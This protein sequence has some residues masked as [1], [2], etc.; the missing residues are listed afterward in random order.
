[1]ALGGF[2]YDVEDKNPGIRRM[3]RLHVRRT[4]REAK[5][6]FYW[7]MRILRPTQRFA[8]YTV[9]TFC[10]EVDDIVDEVGFVKDQRQAL[11]RWRQELDHVFGDS[12]PFHPT[13]QAL[14]N[15]TQ[16]FGLPKACF[17]K[18]LDGMEMDIDNAMNSADLDQLLLYSDRVAGAVGELLIRIF[19]FDCDVALQLAQHQG[20][21]LQLTNILRDLREDAD[22]GRVY[23]PRNLL[24]EAGIDSTVPWTILSDDRVEVVCQKIADIAESEYDKSWDLMAQLPTKKIKAAKIMLAI[25]QRNFSQMKR[26]GFQPKELSRKVGFLKHNIERIAKM[27]MVLRYYWLK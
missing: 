23:L 15:A 12:D 7:A 26:R 8:I 24:Q 16:Q 9:Y 3:L 5:T 14:K 17:L 19:G 18:I 4:V 22:M 6:S 1:M 10:R 11:S 20:R 2:R 25:Y 13:A 21:A 27:A